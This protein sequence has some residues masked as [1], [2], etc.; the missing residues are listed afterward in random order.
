[1]GIASPTVDRPTSPHRD[2]GND[3]PAAPARRNELSRRAL[4]AGSAASGLAAFGL[5]A[6]R[7]G[8]GGTSG[9]RS[10]QKYELVAAFPRDVPYVVADLPQRLP[11]LIA[12]ADD[13]PLDHIDGSVEFRVSDDRGKQVGAPISV[14]PHGEGLPRA[15]LPLRVRFAEPAIYRVT[16]TYAGQ[17]LTSSVQAFPAEQVKMPGIG[18]VLPPVVTPTTAAPAGVSPICTREPVCPFHEHELTASLSAARPVV[19]Q[20]STPRY[21][22]TAICGPVLDLLVDEVKKDPTYAKTFDVIHAEVYA[23]PEAVESITEATPAPIVAAYSMQFEPCVYIADQ[24]GTVVDRLDLIW[25]RS[26][27]RAALDTVA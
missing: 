9:A 15:Y 25:D 17:Q 10:K 24:T 5:A 4:L 8:G 23:N 16:A 27:L 11:F 26:E 1:M 14:E 3:G 13:A 6:C 18:S 2:G 7:D 19:L 20:I 12:V 22:Q 21:C